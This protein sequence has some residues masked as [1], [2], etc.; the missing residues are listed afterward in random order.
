MSNQKHVKKISTF[1]NVFR[2]K[3]PFNS[4]ARALDQRT[5]FNYHYM[6][7]IQEFLA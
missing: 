4:Q 6:S 5:E 3:E 1:E 7:I 2:V